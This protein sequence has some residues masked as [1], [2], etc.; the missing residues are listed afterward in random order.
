M[1]SWSFIKNQVALIHWDYKKFL[2]DKIDT[3]DEAGETGSSLTTQ[4]HTELKDMFCFEYTS[5]VIELGVIKSIHKSDAKFAIIQTPGSVIAREFTIRAMNYMEKNSNCSVLCQTVNKIDTTGDRWWGIQPYVLVVNLDH[6]K[7][8][9]RLF[10][11]NRRDQ[12]SSDQLFPEVIDT[13]GIL[14]TNGNTVARDPESKLFY[15]WNWVS[16]FLEQGYEIH[17]FDER[18]NPFRQFVYYEK[19]EDMDKHNW[20]LDNMVDYVEDGEVDF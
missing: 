18:I 9:G 7:K 20:L 8:A 3:L 17:N 6:F 15:G 4:N 1:I 10:F 5:P 14:T 11:G 2:D 16:K 13:D 19:Q 12:P